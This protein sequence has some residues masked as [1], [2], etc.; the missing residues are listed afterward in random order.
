MTT[1]AKVKHASIAPPKTAAQSWCIA[2]AS[3]V[4]NVY[5]SV[6]HNRRVCAG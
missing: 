6:G 3:D 2:S 4:K 1:D 5:G